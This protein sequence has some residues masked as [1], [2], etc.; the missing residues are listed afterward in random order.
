MTVDVKTVTD[1]RRVRYDSMQD[2]VTDAERLATGPVRSLGNRTFEQILRHLAIAINYSIDAPKSAF[3]VPWY[4]RLMA[5]WYRKRIFAG[6]LRPGFQVPGDADQKLWPE[7]GDRTVA[8]DGLR[9]AVRRLGVETKR[10]SHPVFG[11]LNVDEWNQFHLR[12]AELHMS[13]VTP[14]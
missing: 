5:R 1:R 4:F 13:F 3:S 8:L 7:G 10:G 12:H 11:K 2:V 6:G 14:A 9:Q